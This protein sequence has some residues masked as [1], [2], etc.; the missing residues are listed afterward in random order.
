[1]NHSGYSLSLREFLSRAAPPA[2]LTSCFSSGGGRT[3]GNASE[4]I[5]N[6]RLPAHAMVEML[7]LLILNVLTGLFQHLAS[8][9]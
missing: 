7:V 6:L 2:V 8:S 9:P 4:S 1:M 3:A 5:H